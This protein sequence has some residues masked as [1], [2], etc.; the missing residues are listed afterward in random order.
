MFYT[1][2][3]KF[4]R[5]TR[6]TLYRLNKNVHNLPWKL[7]KACV[8]L[9]CGLVGRHVSNV[10]KQEEIGFLLKVVD[11]NSSGRVFFTSFRQRDFVQMALDEPFNLTTSLGCGETFSKLQN[12]SIEDSR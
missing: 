1:V 9:N 4:W 10:R 2:V 8:S 11:L 3:L 6:F 7:T 12:D 5:C